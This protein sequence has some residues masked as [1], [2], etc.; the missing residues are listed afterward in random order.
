[1]SS[2]TDAL[3]IKRT[4]NKEMEVEISLHLYSNPQKYK[5]NEKLSNILGYTHASRATVLS[6]LWEYIKL[7]R[8][9]D[10]ENRNIINNDANLRLIFECDKMAIDTL[11][12][13]LKSLLEA[14]QPIVL[15]HQLKY[16]YKLY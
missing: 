5:L 2:E 7:N 16:N 12:L 6:A 1:M 3:E 13:R 8:L 11:T 9:Q 4:G 14:P 15:K 10:K